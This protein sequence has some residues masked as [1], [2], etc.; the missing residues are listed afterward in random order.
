MKPTTSIFD[1][2]HIE[3][4]YWFSDD[5]H[6]MNAVVY[7]KCEYEFL[8]IIKEIATK[9]EIDVEI[10]TEP[11]QNGGIRS[12]LRFKSKDGANEDSFVIKKQ[13]IKIAILTY[14]VTNI[15]FTPLTTTLDTITKHVIELLFEDKEIKEL[16]KELEKAKLKNEIAQ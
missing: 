8:G 16:E 10:E 1:I 3:L 7:N 4:H 2:N 5:S 14:L 9:L 15:A 12:W 13:A 6:T 11:L